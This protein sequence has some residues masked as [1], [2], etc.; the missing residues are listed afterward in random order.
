ME[1]SRAGNSLFM[2][3]RFCSLAALTVAGV[4][5]AGCSGV[6]G[7]SSAGQGSNPNGGATA[8][9]GG[10]GSATVGKSGVTLTCTSSDV[11]VSATPMRRLTRQEYAAAA[12]DLLGLAAVATDQIPTDE[13]D[14]PFYS[15]SVSTIT[16]LWTEQY[17]D[18]AESLAQAA[19]AKVDT[20]V[21]CNRA[22]MGDA[23]CAGQFIDRFGTKTY[24]RPLSADE[25]TRY[26]GLFASYAA[27]D[28]FATGI[29]M[30]VQTML[31]SPHF[32]YHVEFNSPAPSTPSQV[33]PLG[34]YEIAA[35]LSFFAWGSIPDDALLAE[36]AG[37]GLA[38]GAAVQKQAERLLADPR[39]RDTIGAFHLQWL[40]MDDGDVTKDAA[41]FPSFTPA[42]SQAM[43][44][45]TTAFAD[46]VFR[47]G[48][49]KLDTLL[50][51]PFSV[52]TAP[53]FDLYGAK[54]P[55]AGMA[56]LVQLD[57]SQRSGILTQ[58][59][60][61]T[62]HAHPNQTSPVS[63]GVV[64][65]R[66]VL[67]QALPDP[68]P[69]VNNAAPDPSPTATTR[70]RFKAHEASVSCGI[71]HKLIDG[72]G[73]GFEN[74]DAIGA[75]R[76]TENSIPIDAS[77]QVSAT[78][79]IDGTFNGAIE[80]TKKLA[81]S[82]EVRECMAKQWF[83]FAL[84]RAEADNDNCSVKAAYDAFQASQYDLPKLLTAI[85]TTDSF[86]YRRPGVE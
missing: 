52:I 37:G 57:P 55:A 50:T 28:G 78:V 12:R 22:A 64:I 13:K 86:R 10:T 80:L 82:S 24:R 5:I 75:Y 84:G 31:Q 20:L 48:G 47:Q 42:L 17:M 83:R 1:A 39:A 45:E 35:R 6:I 18:S 67:C 26:T 30:V 60:F 41:R 29:R 85:V 79:D 59:N 14:G 23:A 77:G 73:F 11:N 21:G 66:N 76:T 19:V 68:P 40:G 62:A 81:G 44:D 53:L 74:Y 15:N 7:S 69:N 70:E 2:V 58:A 9:T 32:L 27:T 3:T 33:L 16:D 72:I 34:P 71:C 25:K 54:Q 65:R 36:A 56:G 4:L 46:Y 51:A 38:D 43:R 63:R 49:G 61:L 8:S